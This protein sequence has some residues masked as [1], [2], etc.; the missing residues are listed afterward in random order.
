MT[1]MMQERSETE[2]AVQRDLAKAVS[3]LVQSFLLE[4]L[5]EQNSVLQHQKMNLY[6]S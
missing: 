1:N 3:T 5:C 6:G 2:N 4:I